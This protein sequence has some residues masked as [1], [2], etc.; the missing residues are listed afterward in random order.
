MGWLYTEGQTRK[1]LIEHLTDPQVGPHGWA[2]QTLRHCTRGNI[3]WTV[4]H[5]TN[6][7]T[8]ADE[9]L[10]AC[11]LMQKQHN[12]GWGYKDMTEEMHPYYYSCPLAYLDETPELCPEWRVR[13]RK[14]WER[15][16]G[17]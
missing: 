2:R 7:T 4:E 17:A 3:L 16:K 9:K 6:S 1:Q 8:G 15:R 13:V 10:I 12:F 5:I 14:Y 11:Y